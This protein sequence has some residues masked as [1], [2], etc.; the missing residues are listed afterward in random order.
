MSHFTKLFDFFL[1]LIEEPFFP[2]NDWENFLE[3]FFPNS[4]EA[5]QKKV[6]L[7]LAFFKEND[8]ASQ[9]YSWEQILSIRRGM[10]ALWAHRVFEFVLEQDTSKIFEIEVLAKKIQTLTNVEIHPKAKLGEKFAI[11]HGHGTVIGE[12]V[13][14]GSNIFIYHGVTLGATGRRSK[15]D[16]RHPLLGNYIFL[17]NGAQILGPSIL[18]DNILV[19]SE[20]MILDSFIESNVQISPGV[21]LSKVIVPEGMKIFGFIPEIRKYVVQEK[22]N[23]IIKKISLERFLPESLD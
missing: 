1:D 14:T 6:Q 5:I 15:S 16:R 7:D 22:D 21:Q 23:S 9:N 20:A 17:G 10:I 3:R 12:T 13:K 4:Q 8:P 11:D 2:L 18:K 19:S